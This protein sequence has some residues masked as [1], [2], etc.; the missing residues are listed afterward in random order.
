MI[1][2]VSPAWTV[3]DSPASGDGLG[4]GNGDGEITTAGLAP[5]DAAGRGVEMG[6]GTAVG[7]GSGDDP[8]PLRMMDTAAIPSQRAC[9]RFIITPSAY[10]PSTPNATGRPHL[11]RVRDRRGRLLYSLAMADVRP[12]RGLRYDPAK[13]EDQGAVLCPPYD[14][15][16]AVDEQRY[17]DHHPCNAIAVELSTASVSAAPDDRYARAA[18]TL[19]AWQDDRILLRDEAPAYYLHECA[20]QFGDERRIRRE[21]IAAVG[22]EPWDRRIVLP[23][24]HTY[25]R[26]KADR[27]ELLQATRA[28]VS[29]ILMFFLRDAADDPI[30]AA[31]S[32]SEANAPV[33]QGV[34]A[35]GVGHRL[36]V[37]HEPGPVAAL[38]AYFASRQLFIADGHHRYETALRFADQST[39]Q[40][41]RVS[42]AGEGAGFVM[43][44]LVADDDPGMLVL[45]IHRLLSGLDGF[46]ASELEEQLSADF[47]LEYF[48]VWEDAP[49]EQ[50]DAFVQ[51]LASQGQVDQVVGMYGP[52][53]TIFAI[54]SRRDRT[55]LPSAIPADRHASWRGLDVVLAESAVVRPLLAERQLDPEDSVEYTRDPHAA[56]GAVRSGRRQLAVLLNP[57]RVEQIAAVARAGERMPGKST[58][59]HPK[60]PTGL[61]MRPLD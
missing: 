35:D 13:L 61:V 48:P 34:D 46:E 50:I 52:D 51:Q 3:Y 8:H 19:K 27:M 28:N 36:W 11:G 22:L 9:L 57:T 54:A 45:P 39:A 10:D 21:L 44:H 56:F 38:G 60:A 42:K 23:H 31:W 2:R 47:H 5:G 15:V 14:V 58:Y 43:A 6:V 25:P 12:F 18:A 59:F 30:E 55:T 32:W 53:F 40:H 7:L 17:R 1:T 49:P 24:E 20:F 4:D 37:L 26:A 33:Y 16:D 29:P 41:H